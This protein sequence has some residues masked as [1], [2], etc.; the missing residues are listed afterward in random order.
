MS[1]I[2]DI[3]MKSLPSTIKLIEEKTA[4]SKAS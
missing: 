4:F 3:E 1:K 2:A